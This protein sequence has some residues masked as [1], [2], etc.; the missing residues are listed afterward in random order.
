LTSGVEYLVDVGFGGLAPI[1]PIEINNEEPQSTTD[2][3]FRMVKINNGCADLMLQWD[4]NGSWIDMYILRHE[5]I[6]LADVDMSNW[7]SCTHSTAR[8][9]GCLFAARPIKG[10]R[11]YVLNNEYC[12]RSNDGALITTLIKSRLELLDI[13]RSVFEINVDGLCH[14]AEC[15]ENFDRFLISSA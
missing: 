6:P 14:A 1:V 15:D 5:K 3:E 9:V 8:W 2:G 11:H 4:R 7:W 12:I 10:A 13:L